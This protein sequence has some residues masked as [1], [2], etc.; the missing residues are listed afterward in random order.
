VAGDDTPPTGRAP[1]RGY[2][3]A[4]L[5]FLLSV[6]VAWTPPRTWGVRAPAVAGFRGDSSPWVPAVAANFAWAGTMGL[7]VRRSRPCRRLDG[8]SLEATHPTEVEQAGWL[9]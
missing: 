7:A 2:P 5:D 3:V 8:L 9:G 6:G 1:Y 4:P